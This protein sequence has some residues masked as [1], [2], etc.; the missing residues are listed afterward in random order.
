MKSASKKRE[1]CI[2]A[3][4]K[5]RELTVSTFSD[6]SFS[7]QWKVDL[8]SLSRY[9]KIFLSFSVVEFL[10]VLF[11]SF[12]ISETELVYFY[13]K[14]NVK[15]ELW[16][17]ERLKT[18]RSDKWSDYLRIFLI[19]FFSTDCNSACSKVSQTSWQL[20]FNCQEVTWPYRRSKK[21]VIQNTKNL[22]SFKR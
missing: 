20:F 14:L 8:Q 3:G 5:T 16:V 19:Y 9:F 6:N 11:F 13:H 18:D 7:K 21:L 4:S 1:I 10:T 2:S 17:A 22:V 15:V 12:I